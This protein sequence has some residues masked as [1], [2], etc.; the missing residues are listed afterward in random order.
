MRKVYGRRSHKFCGLPAEELCDRTRAVQPYRLLHEVSTVRAR[1][2]DSDA[3]L[4]KSP[5]YRLWIGLSQGDKLEREGEET[6]TERQSRKLSGARHS[7]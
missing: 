6:R 1:L 3:H 5:Q 4:L 2:M 7:R